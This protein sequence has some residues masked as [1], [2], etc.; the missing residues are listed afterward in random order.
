[1]SNDG[2]DREKC[3]FYDKE[4]KET[5]YCYYKKAYLYC[6]CKKCE[7]VLSM[8]Q[9]VQMVKEQEHESSNQ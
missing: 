7:H 6:N 2:M 3:V 8:E 9:L 4:P 5:P 1:M